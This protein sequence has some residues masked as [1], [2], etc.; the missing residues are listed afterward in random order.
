MPTKPIMIEV[1][2]PISLAK[3][4][5]LC[6]RT[7]PLEIQNPPIKFANSGKD[8]F[9]I[10][11]SKIPRARAANP[12]NTA[13]RKGITNSPEPSQLSRMKDVAK[14]V[15]EPCREHFNTPIYINSFFRSV[16]LNNV[17]GGSST[18]QHCSGEAMDIDSDG[19]LLVRTDSGLVEK[20]V[21]GDITHCKL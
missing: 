4:A 2:I 8:L 17:I 20:V 16:T 7:K 10:N 19:S 11:N 15:F 14:S 13:N 1:R 6:S 12:R 18:S 9:G 3:A 5:S 21:A